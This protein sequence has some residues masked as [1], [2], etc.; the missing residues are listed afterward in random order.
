MHINHNEIKALSEADTYTVFDPDFI[1][2]PHLFVTRTYTDDEMGSYCDPPTFIAEPYICEEKSH[3]ISYDHRPSR[4]STPRNLKVYSGI[5]RAIPNSILKSSGWRRRK[6][7]S[8]VVTYVEPDQWID[9]DTG[10]I[11]E[12]PEARKRGA[13]APSSISLRMIEA[14]AITHPCPKTKRPFQAYILK[15]RNKRGGLIVDLRTALDRWID[16]DKPNID[17]T[18]RSRKRKS[19]EDFLYERGILSDNQTFEKPLQI[20]APTTKT[21]NLRETAR[22]AHVLPVKGKPDFGIQ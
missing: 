21:D 19:L 13:V 8:D 3:E 22:F 10:E 15:L 1:E 5:H 2:Y 9:I 11:L 17:S 7:N 18:D 16:H 12:K 20:I 6:K 4:N 14:L